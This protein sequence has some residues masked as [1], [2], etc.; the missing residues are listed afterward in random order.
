MNHIKKHTHINQFKFPQQ[1]KNV[2]I[3]QL[4]KMRMENLIVIV[5]INNMSPIPI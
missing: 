4:H 1:Q 3:Q 5:L 2:E